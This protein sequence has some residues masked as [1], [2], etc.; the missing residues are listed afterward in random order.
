MTLIKKTE[1]RFQNT[2][3]AFLA[4]AGAGVTLAILFA[5]KSGS[6]MRAGIG[7]AVDDCLDSAREK[8][9]RVRTSGIETTDR[10]LRTVDKVAKET[11]GK[12]EDTVVRAA[13]A[14]SQAAE[15]AARE[16]RNAIDQTAA[17]VQSGVNKAVEALHSAV[18]SGVNK[19]SEVLHS[20]DRS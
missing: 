15:T 13:G 6:R 2:A 11:A 10:G 20:A 18:Q 9:N 3:A 7:D 1:P 5:P 14:G 19:A 4:G 8:A 16:A 17:A 12:I